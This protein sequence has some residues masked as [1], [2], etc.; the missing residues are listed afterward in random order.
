MNIFQFLKRVFAA[1]PLSLIAI[2][3]STA[4]VVICFIAL[5]GGSQSERERLAFEGSDLEEREQVMENVKITRTAANLQVNYMIES[6]RLTRYPERNISEVVT[7]VLTERRTNGSSRVIEAPAAIFFQSDDLIELTGGV[8]VIEENSDRGT[9]A[10]IM[11]SAKLT[12][13]LD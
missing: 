12:I 6:V 3:L 5:F 4:L 2:G 9:G 10:T 13:H 11:N 1:G 8:E 7:P